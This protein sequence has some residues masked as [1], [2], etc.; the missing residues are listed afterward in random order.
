MVM[1][2]NFSEW[3]RTANLDPTD[4]R[5]KS[6]WQGIEKYCASDIDTDDM[7][8][9]LRLFFKLPVEEKFR[10]AFVNVF[11]KVDSAFPKKNDMELS[12]LAGVTLVHIIEIFDDFDDI[13]MLALMAASFNN[14][15]TSV[16][17]VL[18]KVR[19]I[20]ANKAVQIRETKETMANIQSGVPSNKKLLES[21]KN[22]ETTGTWDAATISGAFSSYLAPLTKLLTEVKEAANSSMLQQRVYREDSQIL[23][24]MTGEWSRDLQ[25]PIGQLN[26]PE[27]CIVAG[28]E[29]ADLVELLPGPYASKA[30]LHKAL[31]VFSEYDVKNITLST[32]IN[33]LDKG[34]RQQVVNIYSAETTKEIT[35]LLASISESLKVEKS[36]EWKPAYKKLTG[37]DAD[38]I[39][40]PALE[41]AYQMYLECL[42]VKSIANN[43]G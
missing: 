43:E 5:L 23:W 20:F 4:E 3:Y 6:R 31:S 37:F 35:P 36:S 30:V 25:K 39:K 40:I 38:R 11:C 1:N 28:K 15:K 13:A 41:L 19:N 24:W 12:V 22:A 9:L 2:P 21:L 26:I 27:A 14:R 10:E 29:L 33:Q 18:T 16:P 32:A 7:L 8:E 17:D 34:W 42:V